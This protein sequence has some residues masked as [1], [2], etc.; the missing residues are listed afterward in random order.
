MYI[1]RN[2]KCEEFL[3]SE[4]HGKHYTVTRGITILNET[5]KK[6]GSHW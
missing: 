1:E 2:L 4:S 3:L 5:A 6:I